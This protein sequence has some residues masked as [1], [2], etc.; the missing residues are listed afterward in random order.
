MKKKGTYEDYQRLGI[1]LKLARQL[2]LQGYI[3]AA[4]YRPL[5]YRGIR[6]LEKAIQTLD[7]ARSDWDQAC[8]EDTGNEG[9]PLYPLD[10]QGDP[11][12]VDIAKALDRYLAR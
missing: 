9:F 8:Y 11:D 6:R 2:I 7:Q 5:T 4:N 3:E 10:W 1:Y 12:L